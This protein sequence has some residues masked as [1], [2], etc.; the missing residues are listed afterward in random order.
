MSDQSAI[1]PSLETGGTD[2]LGYAKVVKMAGAPPT[3]MVNPIDG[4]V[5]LDT[6]GKAIY[7]KLETVNGA[8]TY[9]ALGGGT[10]AVATITGDSG[11]ATPVAGNI[12]IAGTAAKGL[13]F[14]AAGAT[15]TGTIADAAA[16]QKG[17]APL[18]TGAEVT[19]GTDA[20]KIVTA[21]TLQ[22]KLGA[23]T[24]NAFALGDGGSANFKYTVAPTNGQI[25]IGNAG[26][27]PTIGSI[28]SGNS[29][30]TV[31]PGAGTLAMAVTQATTTQLGGGETATDTETRD[32]TS[33]A[34][35]LTPSNI[36][37]LDAYTDVTFRAN[38]I[39]QSRAT[40]GAAPTGATGDVNVMAL[41]QGNIMEQ[42]IIGAGQTIIAPRMDATGLLVSLD[43]T[44]TEGAEYNWGI[45]ANGKHYYTIGTTPAFFMQW[46]FTAADVT[47]ATPIHIG[48]RQAEANNATYTT[49]NEYAFIGLNNGVNPATVAIEDRLNGAAAVQTNTT[50]AWT[51]GQTHT[52][53]VLVS[54]AGV[55]T[56]LIDG[57]APTVPHAFTFTAGRF[58]IPCFHFVHGAAAP[59]NIHWNSLKIGLQ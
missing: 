51:D 21:S 24:L 55:V 34:V 10:S 33:T 35:L 9:I 38:P 39:L 12:K 43:L 5:I 58:V 1:Q 16:A 14:T 32:K 27:P 19:T 23:Q 18:A 50:D 46:R 49:Y 45:L 17:V 11:T 3:T 7:Q 40:T 13:S 8:A 29:S 48:F 28:T 22:T 30:I 31:T 59:G 37:A 57:V 2:P 26:N 25:P 4:T 53:K 41:Q 56:Y 54:A 44:N 52:L 20:T 36:A 6:V 42:F 15:V 47:G